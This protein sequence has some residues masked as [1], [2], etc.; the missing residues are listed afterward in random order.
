MEVAAVAEVLHA[1]VA[2]LTLTAAI[3]VIAQASKEVM[4]FRGEA[5]ATENRKSLSELQKTHDFLVIVHKVEPL[6]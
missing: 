2:S 1:E 3:G 4:T 5:T 6:L